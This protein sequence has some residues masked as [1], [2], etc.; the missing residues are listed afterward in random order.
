[1]D[2][3][4]NEIMAEGYA[5]AKYAWA[6]AKDCN[7]IIRKLGPTLKATGDSDLLK[8][9]RGARRH[10]RLMAVSHAVGLVVA[11][12]FYFVNKSLEALGVLPGIMLCASPMGLFLWYLIGDRSSALEFTAF[13]I[14][15]GLVF[16]PIAF[17]WSYNAE[18]GDDD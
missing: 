1:M 15:T 10:F 9:I 17:I 16:I 13:V 6:R 4:A 7:S 12:P 3:T 5:A 11:I 18:G 14:G 2:K 8:T